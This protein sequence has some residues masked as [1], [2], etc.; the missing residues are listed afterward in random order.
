MCTLRYGQTECA[1]P[2][3]LSLPGDWG[4]GQ[5]PPL[6]CC[7]IKLADCPELEYWAAHGR[8]EVCI[9]GTNVMLGYY[10]DQV[11]TAQTIDSQVEGV[12]ILSKLFY[13]TIFIS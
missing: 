7:N 3:T 2:A 1:G 9:R 8:G 6:P 12:I 10:R 4:P 11:R 5:G 13:A